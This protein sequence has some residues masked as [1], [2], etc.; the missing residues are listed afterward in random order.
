MHEPM[1]EVFFTA[2]G[3]S[4]LDHELRLYVRELRDRSR[5]VDELNR[6]IDQLCRENDINIAFNQLEVH[7]HNEKGD[8]V[9]EVK[10][11]Y[12][13]DDPTPAVG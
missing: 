10:R 13:G 7:L 12:K 11:D 5:T 8:E 9:T 3:A 1:P 2:F 4:T 6:T